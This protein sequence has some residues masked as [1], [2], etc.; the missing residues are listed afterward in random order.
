MTKTTNHGGKGGFR[1][2]PKTGESDRPSPFR[3]ELDQR[4]RGVCLHDGADD[5]PS[6]AGDHSA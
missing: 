4:W 2:D 5:W 1:K 6:G 3:L